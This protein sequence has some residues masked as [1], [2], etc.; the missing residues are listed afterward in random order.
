M[1]NQDSEL[2]WEM[3]DCHHYLFEGRDSEVILFMAIAVYREQLRLQA[4]RQQQGQNL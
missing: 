3:Y 4:I 1:N 2:G